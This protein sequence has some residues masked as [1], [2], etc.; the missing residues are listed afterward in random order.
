MFLIA[1]RESIESEAE[2]KERWEKSYQDLE[3]KCSQH[4]LEMYTN[5]V[6]DGSCMFHS[7]LKIKQFDIT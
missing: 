1:Q 6:G 2:Y 3:V 5:T 4:G 7:K